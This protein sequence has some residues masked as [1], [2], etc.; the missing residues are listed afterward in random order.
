[1]A[2]EITSL[3]SR[4][5]LHRI[6]GDPA[7]LAIVDSLAVSD[8][9]PGELRALASVDWNLLAHHLRILEDAG[10]VE[11]HRSEGDGRRRYVRLRAKTLEQLAPAAIARIRLPLFVCLHNSA[12]SQFAA[13]LWR[14]RTQ[15]EAESAGSRPAAAVHP[16]AVRV[17]A[18]Y[19]LD[20]RGARPRHY[21]QVTAK[22]GVVVSVCDRALE[23]R[24]PFD[25]PA[26]HWSV[27]DPSNGHETAF[28][29]AFADIAERV[30]QIRHGH[31]IR[32][33]LT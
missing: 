13:A 3:E 6:L 18:E 17:A 15:T 31:T 1:M 21:D 24:P 32:P 27:P 4:A 23:S 20:L 25:A 19:G 9:S 12:R 30:A 28:R 11:R 33:S 2:A 5:K 16:L 29:S 14:Q 8:R 26:L 10:L 7:R 22:P